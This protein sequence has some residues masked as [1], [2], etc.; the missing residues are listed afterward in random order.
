MA[1]GKY[2][3]QPSSPSETESENTLFLDETSAKE[4]LGKS[5]FT[6]SRVMLGLAILLVVT[7]TLS[8]FLWLKPTTPASAH[9]Y[10]LV[11]S[12][13]NTKSDTSSYIY[14]DFDDDFLNFDMDIAQKYWASLFPPGGGLVGLTT[15]EAEA[16]NLH[17]SIQGRSDPS[18]H[19]YLVAAFHQFHCLSQL[20]WVTIKAF[21]EPNWSLPNA[22]YLHTMH[23][24]DVIR[25][26][27]MCNT[28]ST[29]IFKVHGEWPGEGGV[30]T[31]KNYQA[32]WDWTVDHQ[33]ISMP[34]EDF[35]PH[36]Y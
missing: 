1:Y 34:D 5:H 35:V 32:L 28:D 13:G 11:D 25:Q 8:I 14:H 29:L 23:C 6:Y 33:Y 9:P 17:T 26:S 3:P 16:M 15:E 18:K 10:Y 21:E 19:V 27:L 7:N 4:E 24:A 12:D 36:M 31:C 22:T 30:R 20:R 2:A